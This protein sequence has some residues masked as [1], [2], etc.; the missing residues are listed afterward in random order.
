MMS[1][2][3]VAASSS[4]SKQILF[5]FFTLI[6]PS[7]M[8]TFQFQYIHSNFLDLLFTPILLYI[9]GSP[10]SC[11]ERLVDFQRTPPPDSSLEHSACPALESSQPSPA[12]ASRRRCSTG[13]RRGPASAPSSPGSPRPSTGTSSRFSGWAWAA[14]ASRSCPQPQ[15]L[16]TRTPRSSPASRCRSE[17]DCWG[18]QWLYSS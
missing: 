15:S 10:K 3:Y 6:S 2:S 14:L 4:S 13:W 17:T 11:T 1:S 12:L 7:K 5:L 9:Y 18:H 16:P 8:L